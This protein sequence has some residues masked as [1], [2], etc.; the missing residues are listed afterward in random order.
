V[1]IDYDTPPR[2]STWRIAFAGGKEAK[3]GKLLS[4]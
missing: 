3:Y 4:R 1:K 2:S